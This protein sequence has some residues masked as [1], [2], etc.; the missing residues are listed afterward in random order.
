MLALID[1]VTWQRWFGVGDAF[2]DPVTVWIVSG[3]AAALAISGLAIWT[4]ISRGSVSQ[5]SATELKQRW[6]SWCWLIVAIAGPILLGAFWTVLAVCLYEFDVL[7]R[8]CPCD[9]IVS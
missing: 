2:A 3:I 4:L 5:E 7:S 9:G 1:E 8:V 6:V